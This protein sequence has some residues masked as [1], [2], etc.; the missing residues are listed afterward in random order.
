MAEHYSM[1]AE[2]LM[3][4]FGSWVEGICESD[5]FGERKHVAAGRMIGKR[6]P[7][8]FSVESSPPTLLSLPQNC[9]LHSMAL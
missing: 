8:A 3:N 9:P 7:E 1:Q 5:S 4:R 2:G 6:L